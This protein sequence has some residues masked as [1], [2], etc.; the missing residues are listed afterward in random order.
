MKARKYK[1]PGIYTGDTDV[2]GDMRLIGERFNPEIAILPIGGHYTMGP[3]DAARAADMI[4]APTVIPVHYGTFPAL[5]G[6]LLTGGHDMPET[7]RR[8]SEGV[9]QDLP[10]ARYETQ[11]DPG[12]SGSMRFWD[13]SRWTDAVSSAVAEMGPTS[14]TAVIPC[15]S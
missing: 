10:I 2:F 5:A 9:Q 3:A 12:G 13:G 8:L 4:G 14:I 11:Q 15:E 6:I 7:I 1:V